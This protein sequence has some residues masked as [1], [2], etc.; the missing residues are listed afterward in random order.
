MQHWIIKRIR[1]KGTAESERDRPARAVQYVI[2]TRE[3]EKKVSGAPMNNKFRSDRNLSQMAKVERGNEGWYWIPHN[4]LIWIPAKLKFTDDQLGTET[5]E[6]SEGGEVTVK[7][8]TIKNDDLNPV[9][10]VSLNHTLDNLVLL[11]DFGEGAVLHQ[12]RERFKTDTIYTNISTILVSLNPFKMLPIYASSIIDKYR[13]NFNECAPHVYGIA[14]DAYKRLLDYSENQA[15]IISGESGAGKTEAT[16][17]VLQY[18]SDVAGSTSNVEQ[19]IL[20]TNPVLE[21]FGNAKTQRNNNS[22]RFG[23]WMEVFFA[24]GGRIVAAQI[25]NYLLEKSRI[26]NQGEGERNYHVFYQ[27]HKG[28]DDTQKHDLCVKPLESYRY[29]NQSGCYTVDRMDDQ[30][31]WKAMQKAFAQLEVPPDEVAGQW[32]VVSSVLN[33]GNLE[34]KGADKGEGCD[35]KDMSEVEKLAKVLKLNPTTMQTALTFRSVTIRGSVSMIP[36]K[37]HEAEEGRDSLAKALYSRNFDWLVSR[38]NKTLKRETPPDARTVGIL[39]IFGFEIFEKNVFEQFCINYANEKLQQH[40]NE[41]IFKLEMA[42]YKKEEISI[43]SIVFVDNVECLKLIEQKGSGILGMLDEEVNMPKGSDEQFIQK[44]HQRY[45]KEQKHP[46]YEQL[47]KRPETFIIKHYAGAVTYVSTGFLEKNRDKIQDSLMELMVQS[48]IPLIKTIFSETIKTVSSSAAAADEKKDDG[49][50]RG[51]RGRGRG[52]RGGGDAKAGGAGGGAKKTS[53]TLGASFKNQ[54]ASLMAT[55]HAA[56]PH[57]IRCIKTNHQKKPNIFDSDMILRQMKY[58]GLFEAIRIRRAGYPFR[59]SHEA[60]AKR[61]RLLLDAKSLVEVKQMA[62][63]HKRIS[64]KVLAYVGPKLDPKDWVMGKFSVLMRNSQR[65]VLTKLRDEELTKIVLKIQGYARGN[66]ERAKYRKMIEFIDRAKKA[67]EGRDLATLKKMLEEL[68]ETGWELYYA[69]TIEITVAFLEEEIRIMGIF[70]DAIKEFEANKNNSGTLSMV[71]A[72]LEQVKNINEMYAGE[73]HTVDFNSKL[74]KVQEI[75]EIL[76]KKDKARKLLK[77]AMQEEDLK[78]LELSINAA[79]DADLPDEEWIPAHNMAQAQLYE[80]KIVEDTKALTAKVD[81]KPEEDDVAALEVLV[82]LLGTVGLDGERKTILNAGHNAIRKAC[83]ENL[84]SMMMAA[85]E[86]GKRMMPDHTF[87]EKTIP[88]PPKEQQIQSEIIPKLVFMK[89]DDIAMQGRGFI[90]EQ[91]KLRSE[92]LKKAHYNNMEATIK[93]ASEGAKD[94]SLVDLTIDKPLA[95]QDLPVHEK[96]LK[97]VIIPALE[98]LEF[99]DFVKPAQTCLQDCLQTR[100]VTFKDAHRDNIEKLMKQAQEE[101]KAKVFPPEDETPAKDQPLPA[102][103]EEIK[104]TWLPRLGKVG[105]QD[106]ADT[107]PPW[108]EKQQQVLWGV[109]FSPASSSCH[110]RSVAQRSAERRL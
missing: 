80:Q 16:K 59:L 47:K 51:G 76:R 98:K 86:E 109:I 6:T 75:A 102:L 12:L 36:L 22:S 14:A 65:V 9:S 74:Q 24:T 42:E 44:M 37:I 85:K 94:A 4:E 5:W 103:E 104:S 30:Q 90:A 93:D 31:E 64:A 41:H 38:L 62:N 77:Q 110:L 61:Y 56:N 101:S 58:A 23:K 70:N 83:F 81:A 8:G 10:K 73:K 78:K 34:F 18:L 25:V 79:V 106:L 48:E 107:I 33:I 50:G 40:F 91:M 82:A 89:F 7:K 3:E 71:D 1:V 27:M 49:G 35:M 95:E 28:L 72:G 96:K 52:R 99:S 45:A 84:K 21:A 88:L 105:F 57:F 55:L 2:E 46:F 108:L 66:Q 11:D 26:T 13:E 29:L 17:T 63:D 43:E 19:Q 87:V 32:I 92:A 69:Q 53:T 100:S 68:K 20:E 39:D 67:V 97:E 15:V 60:F 54:L